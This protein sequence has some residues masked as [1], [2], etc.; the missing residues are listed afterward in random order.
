M[1]VMLARS[2]YMPLVELVGMIEMRERERMRDKVSVYKRERERESYLHHTHSLP[3][4]S[5]SLISKGMMEMRD[6]VPSVNQKLHDIIYLSD[7]KVESNMK[8]SVSPSFSHEE[9]DVNKYL[10][11]EDSDVEKV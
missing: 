10:A 4:L 11:D 1:A 8:Y 3:P 2:L 5:L 7:E 6:K 9:H